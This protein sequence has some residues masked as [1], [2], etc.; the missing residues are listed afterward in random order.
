MTQ[1]AASGD[2]D[3]KSEDSESD[4]EGSRDG[5]GSDADSDCTSESD[6]GGYAS[7]HGISIQ[8]DIIISGLCELMRPGWGRELHG[9]SP[10]G[11]NTT[12]NYSHIQVDIQI[13]CDTGHDACPRMSDE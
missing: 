6:G 7:Y 11:E 9:A 10:S 3:G 5:G 13:L 4:I 12:R 1:P 8:T 2:S